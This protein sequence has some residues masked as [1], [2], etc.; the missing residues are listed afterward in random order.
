MVIGTITITTMMI[1]VI[2]ILFIAILTIDLVLS[3]LLL[4]LLLLFGSLGCRV[5]ASHTL[6]PA[7]RPERL[8]YNRAA[9]FRV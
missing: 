4:L 5:W 6:H 2:V 8:V 9:G 7:A 3:L 1:D